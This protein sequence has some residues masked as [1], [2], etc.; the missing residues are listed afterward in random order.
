MML[1]QWSQICKW[2]IQYKTEAYIQEI[3][4]WSDQRTGS[5]I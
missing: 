1:T 4:G 2:F 5:R 3:L